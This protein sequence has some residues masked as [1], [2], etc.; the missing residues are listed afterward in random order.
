MAVRED[1]R[2]EPGCIEHERKRGRK[3]RT[4]KTIV[5][6]DNRGRIRILSGI[7]LKHLDTP[8]TVKELLKELS[9]H[10]YVTIKKEGNEE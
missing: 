10:G 3:G 7:M 6:M 9:E 2:H 4:I 8:E 1:N 5:R